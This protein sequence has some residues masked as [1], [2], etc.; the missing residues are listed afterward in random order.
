MLFAL[1]LQLF[2]RVVGAVCNEGRNSTAKRCRYCANCTLCV[3]S[4]NG[5]AILGVGF[6]RYA[7]VMRR[8]M[9]WIRCG[10]HSPGDIRL[11]FIWPIFHFLT[12]QFVAC[13]S[14]VVK[15]QRPGLPPKLICRRDDSFN[16]TILKNSTVI[17]ITSRNY[18]HFNGVINT[19]VFIASSSA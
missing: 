11:S 3:C 15:L 4:A 1:F 10:L 7:S 2:H 17:I 13:R 19:H 14:T 12:N 8:D 18:V 16:L 6:V 5:Y 9:S